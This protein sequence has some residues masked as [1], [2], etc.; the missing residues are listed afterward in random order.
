[1]A[2]RDSATTKLFVFPSPNAG[3]FHVAYYTPGTNAKNTL[4]IYDSKGALVYSKVYAINSPY[5][6][7]DVDLRR[8]GHG[9]FQVVL[10]DASGRK[11]ANG[12]VVTQ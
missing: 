5:Q 6:N 3:Q 7:M 8:F 4:N 10:Y 2:I 11:L 9:L 1:M 12:Q